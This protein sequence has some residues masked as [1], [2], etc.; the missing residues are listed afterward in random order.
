MSEAGTATFNHDIVIADEGF[1][2]SSSD[3]DAIK[4]GS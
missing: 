1:I 2:G 4:L 3:T